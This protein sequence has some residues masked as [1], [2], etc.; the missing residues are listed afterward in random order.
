MKLFNNLRQ[1][2]VRK[3]IRP[4][5]GYLHVG[6]VRGKPIKLYCN[7]ANGQ[8]VLG[9]E[10]EHGYYS[11]PT[12]TGWADGWMCA[13][14]IAEEHDF[15][16][17]IYGILH[18]ISDEY[19]ERLDNLSLKSI[20]DYRKKENGEKFMINKKS[21][22]DIMTALD[23][24]WGNLH[25]LEKILNVYFEENM[26]TEIYDKVIEALEED[27]EPEFYNSDIMVA[28]PFIMRWLLE[29]DAGRDEKAA[30]GIDGHPLTSA[31]ELYDFLIW[32]RDVRP[33]ET[34][35]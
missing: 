7:R 16:H 24:Y 13:D 11:I 33:Y 25:K 4:E 32:N 6:T 10:T 34:E 30:E 35:A 22:C 1:N 12:L 27:F 17:W 29:F 15:A 23:E 20:R 14:S 2:I 19:S 9:M 26:L 21:F 18:N 3:L 5:D 8:Y 31:E 28:E